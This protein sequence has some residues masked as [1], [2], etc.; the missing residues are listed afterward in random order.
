[1]TRFPLWGVTSKSQ[2][3]PDQKWKV[4]KFKR[5]V[6]INNKCKKTTDLLSN[7]K[8]SRFLSLSSFRFPA[9]GRTTLMWNQKILI[10]R[11]LQW[12]TT[13]WSSSRLINR[14][15]K[16]ISSV[17]NRPHSGCM[18]LWT[19][20]RKRVCL[21]NRTLTKS[22][23]GLKRNR[24]TGTKT[25]SSWRWSSKR[26]RSFNL[27][28]ATRSRSPRF[29]TNN[30]TRFR[31]PTRTNSSICRN[32]RKWLSLGETRIWRIWLNTA[33]PRYPSKKEAF[34]AKSQ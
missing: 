25:K 19:Q 5:A 6:L 14:I 24:L 4:T 8:S 23:C 9:T 7:N 22:S 13:T 20:I 11:F 34:R 2:A 26:R 15:T 31:S 32:C 28:K 16:T 12:A 33:P 18:L 1:M 30:N 21:N 29:R 3:G 10:K 27:T 17:A